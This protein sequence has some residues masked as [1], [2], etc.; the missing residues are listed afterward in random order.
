MPLNKSRIDVILSKGLNTKLDDKLTLNAD[1]LVLENRVFEKLGSLKKRK[2]FDTL[3]NLDTSS[4]A[5][6]NLKAIS[7]FN[8]D[9]LITVAGTSLYSYSEGAEKW[10]NKDSFVSGSASIDTVVRNSAEQSNLTAAATNGIIVYAWED[11]R[12]GIR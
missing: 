6:T 9:Q 8:R 5:L 2:G 11:T 4:T 10:V 1:L 3:S 12:G 7:T